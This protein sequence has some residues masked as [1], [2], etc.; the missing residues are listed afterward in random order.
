MKKINTKHIVI[1]IL[2]ALAACALIGYFI[3]WEMFLSSVFIIVLFFGPPFVLTVVNIVLLF[4]KIKNRSTKIGIHVFEITAAFI[5]VVFTVFY[6]NLADIAFKADWNVVLYDNYVHTPICTEA[7]FTIVIMIVAGIAGYFSLAFCDVNK[8]PPLITVLAISALY[9]GVFVCIIW[10]IQTAARELMII[11][12]PLNCVIIAVRTVI[13]TVKA[14][15]KN[16]ADTTYSNPV[17]RFFDEKFKKSKLWP[18]WALVLIFPLF[19][20]IVSTLILFGQRPDSFIKAWT[21]TADWTLSTKIPPPNLSTGGHYLCTVALKGDKQIVKPTRCGYRHGEKIIVNRQLCV[22]NA[23]E[24]CIEEKTPR[25]HRAIRNFYDKYGY[26]LSKHITTA[27][28]ANIVYLLMKPLE[29]F[30]VLFLY[31]VDKNPENRIAIQ[32]TKK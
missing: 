27:K 8:L 21:E 32:Y 7:Q 12:L 28:R 31:I 17:L 9:I 15:D 3:D 13:I 19:G 22:A 4:K 29:W 30:F 18:V 25:L 2:I 1:I 5:G 10:T 6:E 14:W 26:P 16:D 23:F 24:Q 20:V 11:I